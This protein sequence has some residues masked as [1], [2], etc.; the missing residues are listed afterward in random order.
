MPEPLLQ[1]KRE[2]ENQLALWIL[3]NKYVAYIVSEINP[4]FSCIS[5]GLTAVANVV[6]KEIVMCLFSDAQPS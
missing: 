5:L 4:L 6:D 1:L 3:L 2:L